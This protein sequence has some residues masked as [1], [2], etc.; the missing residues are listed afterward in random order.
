MTKTKVDP[1]KEEEGELGAAVRRALG[2][3]SKE[4]EEG[5]FQQIEETNIKNTNVS[6]EAGRIIWKAMK[7]STIK[8]EMLNWKIEKIRSGQSEPIVQM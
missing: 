7:S 5:L 1:D 6:K 8:F 4:V 3:G 2:D